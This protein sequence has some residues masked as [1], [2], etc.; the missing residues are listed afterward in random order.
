VQL[1]SELNKDMTFVAQWLIID[2]QTTK[3]VIIKRYESHQP[4]IPQNY[5]GL[6]KTLS[7]ACASLSN[8]IAE[9]LATLET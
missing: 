6:A 1:D 8:E 9:A 7:T 4:I 2:P 5:S 3:T